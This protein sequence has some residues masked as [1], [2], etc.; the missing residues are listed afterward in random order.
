MT[1]N[2]NGVQWSCAIIFGQGSNK[3]ILSVAGNNY[4]HE[5]KT[6]C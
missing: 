1:E 6:K 5:T 4:F 2:Q 3:L